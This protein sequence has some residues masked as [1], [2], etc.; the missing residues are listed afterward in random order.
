MKVEK[1]KSE[2]SQYNRKV[3]GHVPSIK[4][5]AGPGPMMVSYTVVANTNNCTVSRLAMTILLVT[6][7]DDGS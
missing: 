3:K 5:S 4:F 6:K 1:I 7:R 2:K